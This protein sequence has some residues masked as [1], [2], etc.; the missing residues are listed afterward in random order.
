MGCKVLKRVTW[1][2]PRPFQGRFFIGRVGLAMVNQ[3]R[4]LKNLGSPITKLW[5]VVQ[6]AENGVVRGHSR[7]WAMPPFDRAHTT[8]YSTWIETV[9]F[10]RYSRLFVESRRF[11]PTTPALGA[12]VAETELGNILWPSDPVTRE[13]SDPQTQW[14]LFY[15]ELQMSTYVWRSILRPKNS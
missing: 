9:P 5:M 4:D 3:C 12:P 8:S 2:W 13:S 14:T 10:S 1:P 7:S 15:I 6:N 11:W